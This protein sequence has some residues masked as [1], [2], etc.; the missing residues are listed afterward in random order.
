MKE[1]TFSTLQRTFQHKEADVIKTESL[2]LDVHATKSVQVV[3]EMTTALSSKS[4]IVREM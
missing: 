2:K 1:I 4:Q 3:N